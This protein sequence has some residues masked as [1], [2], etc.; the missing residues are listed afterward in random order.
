MSAPSDRA[1]DL[2]WARGCREDNEC[3]RECA[4]A[5]QDAMRRGLD[6]ADLALLADY[7]RHHATAPK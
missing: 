5:A 7:D 4:D 2:A 3:W 1:Y 6:A